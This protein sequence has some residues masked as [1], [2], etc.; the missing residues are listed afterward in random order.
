M[1]CIA[2]GDQARDGDSER[3]YSRACSPTWSHSRK[4]KISAY[5]FSITAF[6]LDHMYIVLGRYLYRYQKFENILPVHVQCYLRGKVWSGPPCNYVLVPSESRK[7][8]DALQYRD[9]A[10]HIDVRRPWD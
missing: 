9:I 2:S 4:P 5:T 8:T 1:E 3:R 6:E 7:V 10:N